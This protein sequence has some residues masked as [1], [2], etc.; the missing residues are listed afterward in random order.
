MKKIIQISIIVIVLVYCAYIS[1]VV[2]VGVGMGS[3]IGSL[4]FLIPVIIAVV[5]GIV[6][7]YNIDNPSKA[8]IVGIF[9]PIAL[10]ILSTLWN[11][12]AI[13]TQK[14]ARILYDNEHCISN[15]KINRPGYY[16][17]RCDD[18]NLYVPDEFTSQFLNDKDRQ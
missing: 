17:Y 3:D 7:L 13:K 2:F 11:Q 16:Y 4:K 18:G 8:L 6:G 9:I 10:I 5:C 1:L 14:D 12:A 15:G